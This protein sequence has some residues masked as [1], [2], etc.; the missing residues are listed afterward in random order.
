MSY[1][2][3]LTPFS[4]Q[5]RVDK[6]LAVNPQTKAVEK[7]IKRNISDCSNLKGTGIKR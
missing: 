3:K 4:D 6:K 7:A 5:T 1:M 2:P